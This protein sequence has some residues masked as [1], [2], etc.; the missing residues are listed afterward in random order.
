MLF[1]SCPAVVSLGETYH[2]AR[3]FARAL[4][5]AVDSTNL[6]K[7]AHR[8]PGNSRG[9][10]LTSVLSKCIEKLISM[11]FSLIGEMQRFRCESMG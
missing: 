9:V 8:D 5:F 3:A 11:I 6:Q 4:G 7:G 2:Q 1:C 10:H